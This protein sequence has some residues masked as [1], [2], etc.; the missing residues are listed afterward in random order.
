VKQVSQVA[1]SEVPNQKR[2]SS[3]YSKMPKD[4]NGR[5]PLSNIVGPCL[6]TTLIIM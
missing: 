1:T 2:T 4:P 5:T 6:A 3:N